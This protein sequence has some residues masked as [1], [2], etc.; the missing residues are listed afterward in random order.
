MTAVVLA[1]ASAV[2]YGASDFAG[3]VLSGRLKPWTVAL[4]GQIGALATA[5]VA[6]LVSGGY[7]SSSHYAWALLAGV[8]T[9]LGTAFLYRGLSTG[10]MGVVAPVSGVVSA[11]LPVLAGLLAG[12]RPAALVWLGIVLALPAIWLVARTPEEMVDHT[13]DH[14][15]DHTGARV[16]STAAGI[17]DGVLAGLGFGL[18]FAAIAQVPDSAGMWPVSLSMA[19]ALVVLVIGT[20]IARE[21][22][23]ARGRGAWL[24][25]VPGILGATAMILFLLASQHGQ[26]TVSAI[27]SSLYPAGTVVLA[28]ALLKETIHRAQAVGLALCAAAVVLVAAG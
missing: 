12:E 14:A 4:W 26:L 21:P 15:G 27:I 25:P 19:A 16:A 24:T 1:L 3:G 5:V 17:R 18:S 13:G 23:V 9:G 6:A 10:R 20:R 7:A 22:L 8:G 28:A 11:V 2:A